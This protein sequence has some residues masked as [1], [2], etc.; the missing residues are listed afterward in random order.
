MEGVSR[1]VV[2]PVTA[3]HRFFV[4]ADRE[5]LPDDALIA[6]AV[7]D[8]FYLGVLSSRVHLRWFAANAS[9]IGVYKGKVRYL[10]TSCFDP[11]PF[12]ACDE[13]T[14]ARIRALGEALDKH[15]KDRQALHPTLTITGMYNVLE[16]LRKGQA[17]DAK[18]KIIHEQG[19][20]SV[21]KQ[22]HDELDAAVAAAYG[23]PA[24]LSDDEILTRLVA[25]N[26]ERAAE[27]KRGLVRWL[28]PDFQAPAAQATQT[29]LG[30]EE[31]APKKAAKAKAAK[32]PWPK[33]LPEQVQAIRS[34]LTA[35]AAP[36][37]AGDI[38][39]SFTGARADR[40]EEVLAALAALGQA[41]KVGE[42]YAAR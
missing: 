32:Q 13:A 8:A 17:L 3:K 40:I 36:S 7:D 28:R 2:T 9:S 29:D 42:R 15:R 11:F 41:R 18:E 4:F 5:V 26:H 16:K 31:A 12:P 37:A 35:S 25:L 23:W 27:E 34:T 6:I 22:I 24:N 30:M 1:Y 20:V 19:L 14:R 21:L 10:K 38:A 39:K 33:A